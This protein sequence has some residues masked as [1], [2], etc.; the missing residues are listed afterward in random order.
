M[1]VS[2]LLGEMKEKQAEEALVFSG[3]DFKGLFSHFQMLRSRADVNHGKVKRYTV[4]CA[5]INPDTDILDI[6]V[7]ML[8]STIRAL[9]VFDGNKN[10][11]KTVDI[12]GLLDKIKEH[13]REDYR[14]DGAIH[15][16]LYVRSHEKLGKLIHLM[17]SRKLR[18]MPLMDD[19][20]ELSGII[21]V[22]RILDSYHLHHTQE[23]QHA[24]RPNNPQM[25]TQTEKT[26]L[27]ELPAD[28]FSEPFDLSISQDAYLSEA[29]SL[30][31]QSKRT[32][33]F[34]EEYGIVKGVVTAEGILKRFL[35][36]MQKT[37]ENIRFRGFSRAG[38][39]GVEFATIGEIASNH[40]DR[41]K[42]HINN[43]MDLRIHLKEHSSTGKRSR[44]QVL[45]HL[46]APG[47]DFSSEAHEWDVVTA[48]RMALS[49][50]EKQVKSSYR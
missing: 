43:M 40:A 25:S 22:G 32:F 15:M 27:L 21:T 47:R 8:D 19:K 20:G 49:R 12:Y 18:E 34:V 26:D 10:H 42:T 23:R 33:L 45:C 41:I 3:R 29:A 44:Y 5:R 37:E 1:T 14:T 7:Q 50:L 48:V 36:V 30:M 17:H 31:S 11:I 46:S 28:N 2:R 39:R 35:E 24:Q 13:L 6:S 38:I 4:P 16:P 9:P